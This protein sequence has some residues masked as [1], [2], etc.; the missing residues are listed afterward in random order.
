MVGEPFA[1]PDG[2]V[3]NLARCRAPQLGTLRQTSERVRG[4]STDACWLP[5][6]CPDAG[7]LAA[8][9]DRMALGLRSGFLETVGNRVPEAQ[10]AAFAH[11]GVPRVGP[12]PRS[13]WLK[14]RLVKPR[15]NPILGRVV[16]MCI[17][18]ADQ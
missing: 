13:G 4:I 1:V 10:R 17:S 2:L 3:R 15:L 11:G 12:A 6:E 18:G 5:L 9:V 14:E 8:V 7:D 16:A